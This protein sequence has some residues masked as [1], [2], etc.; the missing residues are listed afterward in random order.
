MLIKVGDIR[1]YKIKEF[2]Y[3]YRYITKTMQIP[4]SDADFY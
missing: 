3:K 4:V 1:Y 2:N